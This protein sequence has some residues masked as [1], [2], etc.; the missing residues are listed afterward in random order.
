LK[1]NKAH[2]CSKTFTLG[3]LSLLLEEYIYSSSILYEFFKRQFYFSLKLFVK[4]QGAG[5]TQP[6]CS[7]GPLQGQGSATSTSR[8][9]STARKGGRERDSTLRARFAEGP[10]QR[11]RARCYLL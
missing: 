7:A 10:N 3:K 9:C 6:C 2:K 1:K 11:F 4:M 5:T 8:S